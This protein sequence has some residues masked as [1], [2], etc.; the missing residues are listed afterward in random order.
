MVRGKKAVLVNQLVEVGNVFFR[1][2]SNLPLL[3][4]LPGLVLLSIG[5][6]NDP[7]TMDK[8][9][10]YQTA[11]IIISVLGGLL[12]MAIV[13]FTFSNTSGRNTHEGQVA[14]SLNTNGFYSICRH[15]L[16]VANYAMWIGVSLL[17]MNLYFVVIIAL[18]YV[19]YYERII[20]A[21]EDYLIS[22]YA[23]E[24][25]DYASKVP[26]VIPSFSRWN[27]GGLMFC[28]Q[29]SVHNERSTWLALA[30]TF[31]LFEIVALATTQ[32]EWRTFST[33]VAVFF[34]TTI[35]Y[36]LISKVISKYQSK[37]PPVV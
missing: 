11:A 12:R 29:K 15:P 24:Y 21:E 7:S 16:Y 18:L 6:H 22:K 25:R 4:L 28:F 1:W 2:R 36:Y 23:H 26:A 31:V 35:I 14:D 3:V 5:L 30:T 20:L 10:V 19:L 17:T 32:V 34:L 9:R 37:N 27:R 13:G 8:Y 33:L